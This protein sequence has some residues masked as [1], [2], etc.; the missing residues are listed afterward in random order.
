MLNKSNFIAGGAYAQEI[1][2]NA[3]IA[4]INNAKEIILEQKLTTP[5]QIDFMFN[6]MICK[7]E[8]IKDGDYE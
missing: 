8:E 5:E 1:T 4:A 3:A 2:C 6:I 7:L